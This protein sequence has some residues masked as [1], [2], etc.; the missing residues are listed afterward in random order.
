MSRSVLFGF[1]FPAYQSLN[2]L[3]SLISQMAN[4]RMHGVMHSNQSGDT[5]A[6]RE[7]IN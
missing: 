6:E 5:G 3:A 1:L 7:K 2:L 4:N